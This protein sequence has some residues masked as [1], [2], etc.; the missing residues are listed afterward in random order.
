MVT[1][2]GEQGKGKVNY[3]EAQVAVNVNP[4][5][6]SR[7]SFYA[8]AWRDGGP[9]PV[10]SAAE[11]D[12]LKLHGRMVE[13]IQNYPTPEADKQVRIAVLQ[14]EIDKLKGEASAEA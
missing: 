6:I 4:N 11:Y 2:L 7:P 13:K 5:G 8:R 9:Q 3:V 1:L 14:A 12:V 10:P